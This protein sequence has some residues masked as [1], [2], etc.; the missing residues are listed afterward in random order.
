MP[1]VCSFLLMPA[2]LLLAVSALGGCYDLSDPSGPHPDDFV[3][4]RDATEKEQQDQT[5]ASTR[6]V[7]PACTPADTS[8]VTVLDGDLPN[9]DRG[10][11]A[12]KPVARLVPDDET[13]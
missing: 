4:S 7:L 9:A 3:R 1:R 5:Q 2:A 13:N 11:T 8:N 10:A 12:P 6:C